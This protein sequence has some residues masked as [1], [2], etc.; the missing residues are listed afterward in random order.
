MNVTELIKHSKFEMAYANH[1]EIEGYVSLPNFVFMSSVRSPFKFAFFAIRAVLDALANVYVPWGTF[2]AGNIT[3]S[4]GL[5]C[6][7]LVASAHRRSSCSIPD[8]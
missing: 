2:V 7:F 4:I 6:I 8:L 5:Y 1:N 3:Y